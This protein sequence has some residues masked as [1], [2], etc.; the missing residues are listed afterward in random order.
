MNQ[1]LNRV[2][3]TLKRWT[4]EGKNTI[5][6]SVHAFINIAEH[7]S[8]CCQGRTIEVPRSSAIRQD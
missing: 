1:S 7:P 8:E 5:F 4:F 6:S 2:Q 3:V